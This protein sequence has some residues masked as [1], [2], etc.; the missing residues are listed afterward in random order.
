[1]DCSTREKLELKLSGLGAIRSKWGSIRIMVDDCWGE[2]AQG[3]GR[4][5]FAHQKW[6][7]TW[8]HPA[9]RLGLAGANR[10]SRDNHSVNQTN[11]RPQKSI[12]AGLKLSP[13]GKHMF[14]LGYSNVLLQAYIQ[15]PS[16]SWY[17]LDFEIYCSQ[18]GRNYSDKA[19]LV[20]IRMWSQMKRHL[21]RFPLCDHSCVYILVIHPF[22][23]AIFS[24]MTVLNLSLWLLLSL[25]SQKSTQF[26]RCFHLAL[27]IIPSNLHSPLTCYSIRCVDVRPFPYEMC[28]SFFPFFFSPSV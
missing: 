11:R 15:P 22:A 24:Q 7:H 3:T 17:D 9:T 16:P 14:C 23:L 12:S 19:F 1:M 6:T 2:M 28:F 21:F 13:V 18:K 26:L 5:K 8:T 20:E 10:D 27:F 4:V 25:Y